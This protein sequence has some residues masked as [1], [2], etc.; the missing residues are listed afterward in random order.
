MQITT[1]WMEQGLE[2][3]RKGME[4][5]LR[6]FLEHKFGQ[7]PTELVDRLQGLSIEQLGTLHDASFDF[8]S[9]DELTKW[10]DRN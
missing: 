7:L 8:T 9:I 10:L 5:M 3:G 1:S 4:Q 6:K 2:Q